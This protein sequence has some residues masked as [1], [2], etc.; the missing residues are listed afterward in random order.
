MVTLALPYA[1]LSG[2]SRLRLPIPLRGLGPRVSGRR[3]ALDTKTTN[4]KEAST[5][6]KKPYNKARRGAAGF[7]QSA[8]VQAI[9]DWAVICDERR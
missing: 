1:F 5:H 8:T 6:L 3:R 7:T 4:R 2:T 9:R